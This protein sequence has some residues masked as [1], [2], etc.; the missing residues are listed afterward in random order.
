MIYIC[1]RSVVVVFNM[2]DSWMM[3]PSTNKNLTDI[4]E[5][6]SLARTKPCPWRIQFCHIE[7]RQAVASVPRYA[8]SR[9]VYSIISMARSY[10]AWEN[11]PS[12][13]ISIT[14]NWSDPVRQRCATR[15]SCRLRTSCWPLARQ[16]THYKALHQETTILMWIFNQV[17][18]TRIR[19]WYCSL[20][21]LYFQDVK[22]KRLCARSIDV[23]S[24]W[25][26]SNWTVSTLVS[27]SM[28]MLLHVARP[29]FLNVLH[30][31]STARRLNVCVKCVVFTCDHGQLN[32][33]IFIILI[34]IILYIFERHPLSH[35]FVSCFN[36]WP[37]ASE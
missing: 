28:K 7:A 4:L 25:M 18:C 1:P 36:P 14:R 23:V 32:E 10:E 16:R 29:V 9:L 5:W 8:H 24:I 19:T 35:L 27:Y 3:I 15:F 11:F 13:T 31:A 2:T 26:R 30:D 37:R 34:I 17:F 21:F 22:E 20:S 6:W 33:W 12:L